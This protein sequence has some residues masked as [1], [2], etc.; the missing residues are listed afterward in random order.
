MAFPFAFRQNW[1]AFIGAASSAA[2]TPEEDHPLYPHYEQAMRG[3]FDRF[4][5]AGTIEV[6]GETQLF[7]GQ[8]N[9]GA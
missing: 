6:V 7:I 2:Y 5:Q 4:S 8:M 3:V 1:D 9:K